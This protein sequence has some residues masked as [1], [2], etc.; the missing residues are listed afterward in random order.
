MKEISKSKY[1]YLN[2]NGT[3]L[4][5]GNEKNKELDKPNLEIKGAGEPFV[6]LTKELL[7]LTPRELEQKCIDWIKTN[8]RMPDVVQA[9]IY[10]IIN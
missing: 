5:Y 7:R 9:I 8:G 6:E 4:F 3:L 10:N 2:D 1:I